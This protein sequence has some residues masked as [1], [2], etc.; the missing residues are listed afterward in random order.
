MY[1]LPLKLK[2]LILEHIPS[3]A[4]LQALCLTN[5]SIRTAATPWL[6]HTV[7]I[8]TWMRNGTARFVH[9][10][11]AGAG[12][13]LR[14]TRSLTFEDEK[15]PSEPK[16]AQKC[17]SVYDKKALKRANRKTARHG[18]MSLILEMFP[19][20]CLHTFRSV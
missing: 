4:D 7:C 2:D 18:E 12:R 1:R 17:R 11:V 10:M 3:K 16:I 15:P 14:H 19:D 6:Y 8:R 13:H 9:S 20:G 5:K